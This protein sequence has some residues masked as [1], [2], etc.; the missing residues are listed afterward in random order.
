V[1]CFQAKIV[2]AVTAAGLA[3]AVGVAG[4]SAD[5]PPTTDV[6]VSASLVGVGP[7]GR[8]LIVAYT[9][10]TVLAACDTVVGTFSS[11]TE[12]SSSVAV[13][14]AALVEMP[15]LPLGAVSDACAVVGEFFTAGVPLSH[16]LAGRTITGLLLAGDPDAVVT[17]G[18]SGPPRPSYVGLSPVQA[19]TLLKGTPVLARHTHQAPKNGLPRVVAQSPRAGTPLKARTAVVLTLAP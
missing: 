6:P 15:Q 14:V 5:I 9:N 1:K 2:A 18:G 19:R 8:S 10:E 4:G 13:N 17:L 3:L 12:T 7:A 11:V 16:P